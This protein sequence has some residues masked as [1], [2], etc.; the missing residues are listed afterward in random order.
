MRSWYY[1]R[2]D[3]VHGPFSD[4]E[5]LLLAR[6]G[7]VWRDDPVTCDEFDLWYPAE[8]ITGF[9]FPKA[10]PERELPS[11]EAV[12]EQFEEDASPDPADMAPTP[13][14]KPDAQAL[15][16][17][18][19]PALSLPPTAR[20]ANPEMM[21]KLP[22]EVSE[23][24]PDAHASQD[25][26]TDTGIE[27]V[28]EYVE[29]PIEEAPPAEE[30]EQAFWVDEEGSPDG[31]RPGGLSYF[32][33]GKGPKKSVTDTHMDYVSGESP[34]SPPQGEAGE[35]Q[36]DLT[37]V[38]K[39]TSQS[40]GGSEEK[41]E[42]KYGGVDDGEENGEVTLRDVVRQR[43]GLSLL[44]V[45]T[46][47][48]ILVMGPISLFKSCDGRERG[49]ETV[50]VDYRKRSEISGRVLGEHLAELHRGSR[51]LVI[52]P[53]RGTGGGKEGRRRKNAFLDGLRTGFADRVTLQAIDF[54]KFRA[55][56]E[57]DDDG[58]ASKSAVSSSWN[59]P[60]QYWYS[61]EVLDSLLKEHPTC[62]L[63]VSYVDFPADYERL[64]TWKLPPGKRPVFALA[65]GSLE[66]MLPAIQR[67]WLA[68]AIDYRSARVAAHAGSEDEARRLLR[69]QCRIVTPKNVAKFAADYPL[70]FRAR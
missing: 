32:K 39:R 19:V 64:A 7:K 57:T 20:G 17:F 61:A 70:L 28:R 35:W 24:G 47:L 2:N 40:R 1:S 58:D 26:C 67:G 38:R 31:W 60:L 13:Q 25:E 29:P 18:S 43:P 15:A 65:S 63:V 56:V 42:I 11:T 37:I 41:P 30:D 55:V 36:P 44:A 33:K 3:E 48:F 50:T 68:A 9:E 12:M 49:Q 14:P 21:A 8:D 52:V 66:R 51:A 69:D 10:L 27:I 62:N 34:S 16:G 54:P 4:R 59:P 5:I 45:S 53:P 46:A 22:S 6:T 23:T